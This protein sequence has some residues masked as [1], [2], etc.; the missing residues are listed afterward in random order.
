[1]KTIVINNQDGGAGKT[2]TA[3]TLAKYLSLFGPTLLADSDASGNATQIFTCNFQ[4]GETLEIPAEAE[5]ATAFRGGKVEPLAIGDNLDLLASSPELNTVNTELII[6][7]KSPRLFRNWMKRAKLEDVYD[8]VVIDT[9][10][11]ESIITKSMLLAADMVLGVVIPDSFSNTGYKNLQKLVADLQDDLDL[12]DDNDE[13]LMTD[14]LY[15]I[16]NRV[17]FNKNSSRELVAFVND[18]S[19]PQYLGYFQD[20]EI[21][22]HAILENKTVIELADRKKYDDESFAKFFENTKKTLDNIVNKLNEI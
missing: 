18:V 10:N 8:Y 12:V 2:V 19:N 22:N 9:H 20:R 4:T 1:M 3:T 16:I 6:R 15:F 5:L 7:N 21:F 13:P 17:A 14:N 11:D